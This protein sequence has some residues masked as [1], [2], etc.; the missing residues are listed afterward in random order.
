MSLVS[1][2]ALIAGVRSGQLVSFPTDTVPA[3][4]IRPD[5]SADIF[6]LKERSPDKPLILM[7]SSWQEFL[8]FIDIGHPALE[9]WQQSAEK[10]FPGAVT[11]VLPASDRGAKLNQGFTTLGI[12]IPDSKVAIAILQQTGALLTTSANKS[13]QPPLR[14]MRDISNAFPRVLTLGDGIDIDEPLG[15]G[16]PSTVVEWTAENWLVRRQGAIKF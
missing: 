7:A 5:R 9:I 16:L 1:L 4:A 12:R 11:L 3:L 14:K 13:N 6:T 15:S 10:Y 8:P 2:A